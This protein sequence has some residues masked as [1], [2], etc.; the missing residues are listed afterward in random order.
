MQSKSTLKRSRRR[1]L[2]KDCIICSMRMNPAICQI[3][4]GILK[5]KY[6]LSWQRTTDSNRLT[7][8]LTAQGNPLN[9][10]N[11][12]ES[13]YLSA[14]AEHLRQYFNFQKTVANIKSIILERA[15]KTS[16]AP[17]HF[18][19]GTHQIMM[20]HQV[21]HRILSQGRFKWR[22]EKAGSRVSTDEDMKPI[23]NKDDPKKQ[24]NMEI[25]TETASMRRL[26]RNLSTMVRKF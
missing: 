4:L 22:K 7:Q 24:E 20:R 17:M 13:Q 9:R 11:Y 1:E 6:C 3:S 16:I 14:E 15:N 26:T 23:K 2:V 25:C 21:S 12:R 18:Y 10:I 19:G 8:L 5:H